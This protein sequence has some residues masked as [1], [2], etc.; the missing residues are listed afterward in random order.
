MFY[1]VNKAEISQP[2]IKVK[3]QRYTFLIAN[4]LIEHKINLLKIWQKIRFGLYFKYNTLID[5]HL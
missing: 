5:I 3:E 2:K 4:I 1:G